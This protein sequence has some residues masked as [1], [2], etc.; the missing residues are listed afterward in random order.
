MVYDILENPTLRDVE[1]F[2]PDFFPALNSSSEG[3]QLKGSLIYK[4]L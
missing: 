2:V 4:A 3:W 1:K